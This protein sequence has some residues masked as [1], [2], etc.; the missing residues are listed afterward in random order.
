[1]VAWLSASIVPDCSPVSGLHSDSCW[2]SLAFAQ[3]SQQ[4]IIDFVVGYE[5]TLTIDG[6]ALP[7]TR[8][9]ELSASGGALSPGSQ[10][11]LPPTAVYDPGNHVLSFQPQM[12][13]LIEEFSQGEHI[14]VVTY[15][16]TLDGPEKSR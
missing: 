10:V 4:I 3:R 7:V 14:A 1:M 2:W 8:L 12:G 9:D 15:W 5:A 11:E 6:I 16:K 13:A